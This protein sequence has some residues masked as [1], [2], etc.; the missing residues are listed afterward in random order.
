MTAL[1]SDPQASGSPTVVVCLGDSITRGVGSFDWVGELASRPQNQRFEFHNLGVDGDLAYSALGR[2]QS[3]ILANPDVVVVCVGANDVMTL[4]IE[5]MRRM[6]GR[7]K[8]LPQDPSPE[9]FEENLEAIV[10]RLRR[11]TSSQVVLVSPPEMGEDP[12]STEPLQSELNARFQQYAGIVRRVADNH[13]VD[14]LPF[15][16]A[17]HQQIVEN[18]GRA[19]TGFSFVG[20]YRN[21]IR[22]YGL[23]RQLDDIGKQNGWQFHV[24]GVHLNRRGGTILAELVQEKLGDL[25]R[26][27]T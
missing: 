4:V 17:M 20:Y 7:Q 15:Y 23:H 19:S 12:T 26:A 18:P 22:Q 16:E 11:G 24:D 10:G 2:L 8:R 13:G 3:V 5:K 6:I 1:A 9:W 14:Y 21:L 25:T 27:S